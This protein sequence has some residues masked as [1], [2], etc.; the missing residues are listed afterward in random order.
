[1]LT[2]EATAFSAGKMPKT[3]EDANIKSS[4]PMEQAAQRL[5]KA[6]EKID[7][8]FFVKKRN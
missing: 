7:D 6:A 1:V 8:G 2:D 4:I 3:W 5:L